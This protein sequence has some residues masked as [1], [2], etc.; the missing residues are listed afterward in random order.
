MPDNNVLV[1]G[2]TERDWYGPENV[3][4]RVYE[5]EPWITAAGTPR[6]GPISGTLSD[7]VKC[8]TYSKIA[9][10]VDS[11]LHTMT[12]ASG[13]LTSTT[14][15]LVN[16]DVRMAAIIFYFGQDKPYADFSCF[17]PER[18]FAVPPSPTTTTWGRLREA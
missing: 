2:G 15:A 6:G 13:I 1:V 14:D 17:G 5:L 11:E 12:Y 8:K 10:T 4:I 18:G 9:C 16:S 3:E 7:L